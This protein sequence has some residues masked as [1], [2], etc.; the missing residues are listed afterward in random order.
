M[1]EVME[2]YG[3][4]VGKKLAKR[5]PKSGVPLWKWTLVKRVKTKPSN[6]DIKKEITAKTGDMGYAMRL[7]PRP[8]KK[9][10]Q[11]IKI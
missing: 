3:I 1:V 6:D 7:K 5:S 4:Y 9:V 8:W 11:T 10:S 2:E